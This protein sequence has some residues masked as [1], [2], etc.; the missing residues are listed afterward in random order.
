MV[1]IGDFTDE[2][3]IQ[4]IMDVTGVDETTARFILA[5]EKGE[6]DGDVVELGEEE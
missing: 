1:A 2:Q 4:I 6:I 5:I 3:Q